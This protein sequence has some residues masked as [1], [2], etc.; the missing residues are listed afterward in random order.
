MTKRPIKNIPASVRDR[1]RIKARETNRPFQ[2]L[3]QYYGMERFLYRLSQSPHADKFILKGALMLVVWNA[4]QFRSTL[5]IDLLGKTNNDVDSIVDKIKEICIQEVEPDGIEFDISDISGE[6]IKE[7]ADYEGVRV[8][9]NGFLNRA[10]IT[11]QI[12]IGFGDV[13]IPAASPVDYPIILDFPKPSLQGYSKE[14]LVAEKFEAMVKLGILNSRMKDFYDIYLLCRQFSF[15]GEKLAEAVRETFNN[16]KTDITDNPV[17]FSDEFINDPS[18]NAQW[19][20]FIKKNRNANAPEDFKVVVKLI[21]I[22]LKPI[23]EATLGE[24][25]HDFIWEYPNGWK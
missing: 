6:R 24:S 21:A 7:D 10:R 14:S 2:E 9:F 25:S 4:S 19:R 11:M 5:D 15:D 22:F 17:A 13:I 18:K 23:A 12:D 16:R 8:K 20:A 3:L 1:L